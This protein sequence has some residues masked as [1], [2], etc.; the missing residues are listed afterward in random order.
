MSAPS[1]LRGS[2]V[3]K[4]PR[5]TL[6]NALALRC[7][8]FVVNWNPSNVKW[9]QI[10]AVIAVF[11]GAGL[12]TRLIIGPGEAEFSREE[13]EL[14]RALESGLDSLVTSRED[15]SGLDGEFYDCT[16]NGGFPGIDYDFRLDR[17][18]DSGEFRDAE[19]L[20]VEEGYSQ[21]ASSEY[22]DEV[23]GAWVASVVWLP[24]T[25]EDVLY[26]LRVYADLAT[27]DSED[28]AKLV[29]ADVEGYY[30]GPDVRW[31]DPSWIKV[32]TLGS[33]GYAF[34]F[35]VRDPDYP[36][37]MVVHDF[38]MVRGIV[39]A[40]LTIMLPANEATDDLAITIAQ[41]LDE[42]TRDQI[43]VLSPEARG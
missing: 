29:R 39:Y 20:D 23:N 24:P 7:V 28:L 2:C 18:G 8:E 42:R 12:I 1:V 4:E 5:V 27:G 38:T 35:T 32:P 25:K 34:K 16:R 31:S 43:A 26:S 9:W 30:P 37:R 33:G 14:R 6:R 22:C 21:I 15:L 11:V 36:Q 41:A 10:G 13:E 19:I 3:G 17:D 40:T